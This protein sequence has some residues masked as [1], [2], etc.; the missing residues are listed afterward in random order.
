MP[1]HTDTQW[2]TIAQRWNAAQCSWGEKWLC[3][4]Y[5]ISKLNFLGIS[6]MSTLSMAHCVNHISPTRR[7]KLNE[8][9]GIIDQ[10]AESQN[11][12]PPAEDNW[13]SL[14]RVGQTFLYFLLMIKADIVPNISS[15]SQICQETVGGS[16][17]SLTCHCPA[18]FRCV[19]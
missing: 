2:V 3:C 9:Q 18:P 10:T 17:F 12:N 4:C 1:A 7:A 6:H 5:F 15:S 13:L 16:V 8:R 19:V 11:M 14:A